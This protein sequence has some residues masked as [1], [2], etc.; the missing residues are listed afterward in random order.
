MT[1]DKRDYSRKAF[2]DNPILPP[3]T[4][5]TPAHA[6]H[7]APPGFIPPDLTVPPPGLPP[8]P[9]G[10]PPPG[11]PPPGLPPPPASLI[12]GYSDHF[13]GYGRFPVPPPAVAPPTDRPQPPGFDSHSPFY[14]G[15]NQNSYPPFESPGD[16]QWEHRDRPGSSFSQVCVRLYYD[17]SI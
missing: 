2:S 13:G 6:A 16:V 10:I 5:S 9:P 15:N 11:L 14:G 12:P 7:I 8:P 3:P 4:S 17:I 1:A